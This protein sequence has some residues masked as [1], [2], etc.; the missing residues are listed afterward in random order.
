MIHNIIIRQL[1]I[2]DIND[3]FNLRLKSLQES[4]NNFLASYEEEKKSGRPVFE[5][6]LGSDDTANIIFG[7]FAKDK[8]IGMIGIYQGNSI[9]VAH[10][11]YLWGVYVQSNYRNKTIGK[12]LVE[13]AI[14]H[15][16]E[17]TQ[18][19]SINLTVET[20]NIAAKKLYESYGFKIWGTE[21]KSMKI[22]KTFYDEF[23]MS[24]LL[25]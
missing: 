16:K 15:V 13:I 19:S 18:C 14:K 6:I 21:V 8:I 4:P 3:C 24:L 2:N 23:H 25:K 17:K 9:K 10:K 12:Q 22:D 11:C 20:N 5:K 7:A 1:T